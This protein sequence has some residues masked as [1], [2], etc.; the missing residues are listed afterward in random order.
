MIDMLLIPV[1]VTLIFHGGFWD[2]IDERLNK[3]FPL[4]HIGKPFNCA[5]CQTF[6][7]CIIYTIATGTFS[8]P[9]MALSLILAYSTEL[10]QPIY[11]VISYMW[12]WM[13]ERL[14]KP[15]I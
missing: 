13:L 1:I 5:F 8:I 4:Y 15:F 10:I 11:K 7:L 6:W 14:M 12:N 9:T 3:K 2:D